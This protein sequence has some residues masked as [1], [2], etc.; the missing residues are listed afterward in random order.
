MKGLRFFGLLTVAALLGLVPAALAQ[1]QPPPREESLADA[2]RRLRA[3]K[4]PA[5]SAERVLT[6]DNLAA[7]SLS[8]VA[9]ES[10]GVAISSG[11][12]AGA[13][14]ASEEEEK[15]RGEAEKA[16]KNEKA[17]LEQLK[18][19]LEL[20]QR[21]YDLARQQFYSNPAYVNDSAGQRRV[22][23]QQAQVDAKKNDIAASEAT[24][25]ELDAKLKDVEQ[26]LGPK[27][28]APLTADE[29]QGQWGDRL[30]PLQEEL[31]QVE[32]EIAR[33]R[34]ETAAAG[35]NPAAIPAGSMTASRLQQ[36]EAKRDELRRKVSDVQDEARRTGAPAGWTRPPR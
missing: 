15:E 33:V 22:N 5:A 9:S 36:L 8:P 31:A 24:L 17:R 7:G 23:G 1:S 26:R 19:D 18:R 34:S 32:A 2:A 3:Q 12:G 10:A 16:L 11:S 28:Q 20:L 13:G 35:A 14:A 6:N 30:R 29:Q 21:D 25:K 27:Q 4:K